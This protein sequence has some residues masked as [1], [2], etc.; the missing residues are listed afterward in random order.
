MITMKKT[1]GITILL[2]VAVAALMLASCDLTPEQAVATV[3]SM[4]A[5][6]LAGLSATIEALS[7]DQLAALESAA[8]QYGVP[9]LSNPQE[10]A[11]VGTVVAA[12]ATA[13]QVGAMAASGERI[14][15]TDAPN[16]APFIVYF[17]ASAPDQA[18]A[19]SGIRYLLN[20]TTQN[21]NRVEIFG[22]VM[23]NPVEGSWA[24]YSA[25][26]NWVLWAANDQVWVESQLQVKGDS[27]TGASL[28]NVTV[29]SRNITL[30]YRDP[31][32]VDGDQIG[33]DVNGVR[34]LNGYVITGRHVSF[35]VVLQPGTNTV[36]IEAQS[37]GVTS[38]M[39]VEVTASNVTGGPATQLTRG[40]NAGERQD[41]TITAP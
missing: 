24:V 9:T 40:L 18:Q 26:D 10:T 4:S 36:S 33:V 11:I 30:T 32:F 14:N 13:T 35:P 20:W 12:R 31:Q 25:S 23:E 28:Q 8:A 41:F 38:P 17:F 3:D 21:A 29:N 7:P 6:E 5:S 19:Q 27:D 2:L 39:V 15:A 1:V 22:H 37:V 34:V 16:V